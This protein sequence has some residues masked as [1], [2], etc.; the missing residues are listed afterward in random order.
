MQ[1]DGGVKG[2]TTED[3]QQESPWRCQ[4]YNKYV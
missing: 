2:A 4:T 3:G 1:L